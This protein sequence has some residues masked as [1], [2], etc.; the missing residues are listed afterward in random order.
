MAGRFLAL[1]AIIA[2]CWAGIAWLIALAM[3]AL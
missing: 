3:G 1:V 2:V